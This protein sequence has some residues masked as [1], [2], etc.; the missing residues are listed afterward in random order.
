[1]ACKTCFS[2][3]NNKNNNDSIISPVSNLVSNLVPKLIPNLVP[4]LVPDVP[5]VPDISLIPKSDKVENDNTDVKRLTIYLIKGLIFMV[6]FT[7]LNSLKNI[8]WC[9]NIIRQICKNIL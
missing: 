4:N 3:K 8:S 5:D 2:N 9:K 6:L 1:M 7:L